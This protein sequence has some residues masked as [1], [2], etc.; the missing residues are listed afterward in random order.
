[1]EHEGNPNAL[2]RLMRMVAEKT[3][4]EV[5]KRLYDVGTPFHHPFGFS[6]LGTSYEVHGQLTNIEGKNIVQG[7]RF[8]VYKVLD[9]GT[10]RDFIHVTF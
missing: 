2:G 4:E 3:E 9:D 7:V 8:I 6:Y 5:K 10:L 1:M